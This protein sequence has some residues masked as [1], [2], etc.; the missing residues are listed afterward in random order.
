[1]PPRDWN[2]EYQFL[3]E[4]LLY[5]SPPENNDDDEE[6]KSEATEKVRL[7]IHKFYTEFAEEIG[8]IGVKIVE[9]L[10]VSLSNRTVKP[11]VGA[12]GS[13]VLGTY[14]HNGVL[15]RMN[16]D[17]AGGA[18]GGDKNAMKIANQVLKATNFVATAGPLFFFHQPLLMILTFRGFRITASTIPPL[19]PDALLAGSMDNGKTWTQPTGFFNTLIEEFGDELGLSPHK[20][21]LSPNNNNP[22]SSSSSSSSST[23]SYTTSLPYDS[24][25][26]GGYDQRF[27]TMNVGRY[28]PPIAPVKNYPGYNP[29]TI[30][31]LFWRLR[32]ELVNRLDFNVSSDAFVPNASHVE[33]NEDAI[34]ASTLLRDHA[35]PSV[36]AALGFLEPTLAPTMTLDRC[37]ACRNENI[38][39]HLVFSVCEAECC[40]I[41]PQCYLQVQ[42][43]A[44]WD[45]DVDKAE[46]LVRKYI[47]CDSLPR[48]L[49]GFVMT[50]DISTIM[51]AHGVNLRYMNMVYQKIPRSAFHCTG[52]YL[53]I[54]M[55]ARTAQTLLSEILRKSADN[56]DANQKT[57]QFFVALLQPSG[58][59]AERFWAEELG[60]AIVKNYDVLSPFDTER[61]DR[62]L[63]YRR[64]SELTGV[65][66]SQ[67]SVKSLLTEKPF[68]QMMPPQPVLKQVLLPNLVQSC[69]DRRDYLMKYSGLLQVY[70]SQLP[71]RVAES[72]AWK[73]KRPLH[74]DEEEDE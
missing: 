53:E 13:I 4:K 16:V 68:V 24:C 65:Q 72:E 43:I 1:M 36:A 64:L 14:F 49:K 7:D 5:S 55:I 61:L 15:Y 32:P 6:K 2:S 57:A 44:F 37:A 11:F 31:N 71:A 33:D 26:I 46:A 3:I 27:Y 45:G 34:A 66:F 28:L 19:R 52:H 54:E 10:S 9:E 69:G 42:K 22:S 35:I 58:E 39:D 59:K 47:T 62:D 38:Q 74:F 56:D 25:I 20:V 51:H 63:V 8:K 29:P 50:P 67:Q 48:T 73:N 41:C 18:Y 12:S 21:S 17:S 60:P 40:Q 23:M 30:A 70:W